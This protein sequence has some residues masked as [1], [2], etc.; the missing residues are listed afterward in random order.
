MFK[1][2]SDFLLKSDSNVTQM[3]SSFVMHHHVKMHFIYLC[4]II[5]NCISSFSY[6]N[7]TQILFRSDSNIS[8]K[9]DSDVTQM[10]FNFLYIIMLKCVSYHFT[11]QTSCSNLTQMW[12]RFILISSVLHHIK[13]HLHQFL[14]CF[15]LYFQFFLV[16]SCFFSLSCRSSILK[17]KV[18]FMMLNHQLNLK[19]KLLMF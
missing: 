16:S 1:S 6:L 11:L 8:F 14:S 10:C 2:D 3:Y 5:L 18:T 9:S 4:I 19:H 15:N 7:L 17:R 12:L 13:M